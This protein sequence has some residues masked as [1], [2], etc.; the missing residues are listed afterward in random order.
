MAQQLDALAPSSL[1]QIRRSACSG[2][3]SA[4]HAQAIARPKIAHLTIDNP[5]ITH[6][7]IAAGRATKASHFI[8]LQAI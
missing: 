5:T 7:I 6:P 3:L 1:S 2:G 8:D 4:L